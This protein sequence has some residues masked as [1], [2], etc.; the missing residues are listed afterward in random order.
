MKKR[1]CR[2]ILGTRARCSHKESKKKKGAALFHCALNSNRLSE[3]A[4]FWW[5]LPRDGFPCE[6][7]C[8]FEQVHCLFKAVCFRDCPLHGLNIFPI[9]T[10][11]QNLIDERC[12]LGVVSSGNGK[13]SPVL[14]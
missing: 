11:R 2:R 4:G 3:I 10:I 6:L 12:E 5:D 7:E 9:D 13:A 1:Q 14:L 8:L